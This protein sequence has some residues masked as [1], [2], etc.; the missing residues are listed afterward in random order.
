M[1]QRLNDLLY[2]SIPL[3]FNPHSFVCVFNHSFFYSHTYSHTP[4]VTSSVLEVGRRHNSVVCSL[5][6]CDRDDSLARLFGEG[7]GVFFIH[8]VVFPI[9]VHQSFTCVWHFEII[10]NHASSKNSFI[11]LTDLKV[12]KPNT[13][14][15]PKTQPIK[16]FSLAPFKTVDSCR[17]W[18]SAIC[19][20]TLSTS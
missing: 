20:V 6:T 17:G 8:E 1:Q 11:L 19:W 10:N 14:T 12:Q 4:G 5:Q 16:M 2:L 3:C 7:G 18:I 13:S 9:M 15:S